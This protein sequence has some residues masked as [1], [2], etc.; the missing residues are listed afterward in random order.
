MIAH[1]EQETRAHGDR[2]V[3]VPAQRLQ[4]L[5]RDIDRLKH[6]NVL[7]DFQRHIVDGIYALDTPDVG[8]EVRS[9]V[10]VATP[11]VAA[12]ITL[13]RRGRSIPVSIPPGYVGNVSAPIA[14]E[15]YLN[16]ALSP[17]GHR[18]RHAPRIPKKLLAVRSG[19]GVYGRNNLCYVEGMGSLLNLVAFYSDAPCPEGV[20]RPVRAMD[21]CRGCEACLSACPTGAIMRD[22]FLIDNTRCLTYLNEVGKEYDGFPEW[23]P[24]SAHHT[25]YGCSRCLEVCPENRAYIGRPGVQV[26]FTEEETDLLLQG[27]PLEDLSAG[28]QAKVN[29]LDMAG[30]LGA[31][32][33][34]LRALGV[35]AE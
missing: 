24:P 11:S 4:E 13:T 27:L 19:L 33:R 5:R 7:N 30:Y 9:I 35:T 31:L 1:I 18:V 16:E 25:A 3:V 28:L 6:D 32:P 15:R 22:R 17:M 21:A 29:A 10:V 2:A 12:T 34:N 26:A 8:L 14:I 20:W 23:A